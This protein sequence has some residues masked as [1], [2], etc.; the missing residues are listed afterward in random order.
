MRNWNEIFYPLALIPDRIQQPRAASAVLVTARQRGPS[1]G[2][3]GSAIPSAREGR[4][5]AH[6][7][8]IEVRWSNSVIPVTM[9]LVPGEGYGSLLLVGEFDCGGIVADIDFAVH[10]RARRGRRVGDEIDDGLIC[11]E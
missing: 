4:G 10:D 11:F 9:K 1:L 2:C 3:P 8:G 7:P 6:L 5:S